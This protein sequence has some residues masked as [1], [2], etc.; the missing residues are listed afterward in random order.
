ML[1][2]NAANINAIRASFLAVANKII[3]YHKSQLASYSVPTGLIAQYLELKDL[4]NPDGTVVAEEDHALDCVADAVK[5]WL[6]VNGNSQWLA[7]FDSYEPENFPERCRIDR[8]L[9]EARSGTILITTRRRIGLQNGSVMEIPC[10]SKEESLQLLL[11]RCQKDDDPSE[12]ESKSLQVS[13]RVYRLIHT[14]EQAILIIEELGQFPLAIDQA[15]AY[16]FQED[17]S[18]ASYLELYRE[19]KKD[20]LQKKPVAFDSQYDECV[21]TTWETSYQLLEKRDKEAAQLLVA[22]SFFFN[23][24]IPLQLFQRGYRKTSKTSLLIC[25][26]TR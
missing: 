3:A 15:G 11:H 26:K 5:L 20:L 19:N 21:F 14:G 4:V 22:C 16:I 9:P 8:Y 25:T 13:Y 6:D 10:F 2:F 24:D 18:F 23:V 12:A 17:I 7:V 1:W